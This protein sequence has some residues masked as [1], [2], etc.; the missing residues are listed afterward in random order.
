MYLIF[1]LNISYILVQHLIKKNES[2]DECMKLI[3]K[4]NDRL[5]IQDLISYSHEFTSIKQLKEPLCEYLKKHSKKIQSLQK[6]IKVASQMV[7]KIHGDLEKTNAKFVIFFINLKTYLRFMVVK[8]SDKCTLCK[9]S[10]LL[11]PFTAYICRHF[12]H[13]NCLENYLN[14]KKLSQVFF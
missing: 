5:N 3:Q 6:E 12:I 11:K 14:Q 7:N 4:S 9:D 8:T 2:V 13:I 1:I 10:L